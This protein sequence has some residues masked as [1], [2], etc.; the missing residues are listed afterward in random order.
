MIDRDKQ[1]LNIAEKTL[2]QYSIGPVS[3]EKIGDMNYVDF[4]ILKFAVK[5]KEDRAK[6]LLS[7]HYPH[8]DY[9]ILRQKTSFESHHLWLEALN[10]DT[11]IQVQEP[12][13]NPSG[14]LL[15]SHSTGNTCN[16]LCSLLHWV[17][18][19]LVSNDDKLAGLPS[20]RVHQMGEVLATIHRHAG[21][22]TL[23]QEFIRPKFDAEDVTTSIEKL[24]QVVPTGRITE[25]DFS[26]IEKAGQK[27]CA[28]LE[29]IEKTNDTW[30]LVHGDFHGA[31]CIL[32]ENAIRPIDF[33]FCRFSYFLYD[34]AYA[35]K[36][37]EPDLRGAFIEGYTGIHRLPDT[38]QQT[39][40]AL[41]I[42]LRLRRW[43]FPGLIR[44]SSFAMVPEIIANE[45]ELFLSN[46]SFLFEI[47]PWDWNDG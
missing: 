6:F 46:K 10:R 21:R 13:R 38:Y 30:G 37:L 7:I 11:D 8:S 29:S 1:F 33:D 14:E 45:F 4:Q 25:S 16:A 40:E 43:S 17:E 5:A 19:N 12:M 22:W 2:G 41:F 47:A 28:H 42:A 18:G 9:D 35:F 36:Y 15:T 24:R 26:V 3:L 44:R 39:A 23:P 32:S 34:I 31:N 27:T 20:M